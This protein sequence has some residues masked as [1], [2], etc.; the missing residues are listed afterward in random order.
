EYNRMDCE[1][2]AE[3]AR[4][5]RA[6]QAEARSAW[7]PSAEKKKTE[8]AADAPPTPARTLATRL[9]AAIPEN[10]GDDPE[11]WR[12]QELLATLL[13]FHRR[14]EKPTWWARFDRRAMT[15]EELVLDLDCL[16]ALVRTRRPREPLRKSYLYEYSYDP[17]Q[18]TKLGPES[19]CCFA[20]DLSMTAVI[21]RLDAERGLVEIKVGAANPE[22]PERLSLI[23]DEYVSSEAIAASILRTVERWQASGRLP[24]ALEDFLVRRPPRIAGPAPG[25]L[26]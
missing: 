5:L 19:K 22:P 9:L 15:E 3:L 26:V 16:G 17:D 4:W 7:I 25:Q 8:D 20:H 24:R 21:T 1:S 18:D 2:L 13:E 10:R 12:I 11:R 23:P 6:R 14:E